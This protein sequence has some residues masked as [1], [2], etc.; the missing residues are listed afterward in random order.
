MSDGPTR[1]EFKAFT[2]RLY[3]TMDGGFAAINARL[4]TQNGRVGRGE[5][6]SENHRT[7]LV[8]LE[9]RFSRRRGDGEAWA[10]DGRFTK[11]EKALMALGMTLLSI[12]LTALQI[13]GTKAWEF[14]STV[15]KP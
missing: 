9:R 3:E 2:E 4:D 11:R 7:R 12:L 14:V 6:E 10:E 5:V 1:E 8:S 15:H 13:V